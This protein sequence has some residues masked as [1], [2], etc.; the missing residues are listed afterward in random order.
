MRNYKTIDELI[1]IQKE[2]VD[3][4]LTRFVK[5]ESMKNRRALVKAKI[6]LDAYIHTKTLLKDAGTISLS[7]NG[8][9]QIC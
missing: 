2:T 3:R 9:G 4:H 8:S 1:T 5:E 7:D 6:E